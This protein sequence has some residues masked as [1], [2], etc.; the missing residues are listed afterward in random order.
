MDYF[1]PEGSRNTPGNFMLQKVLIPKARRVHQKEERKCHHNITTVPQCPP[2][3]EINT[4]TRAMRTSQHPNLVGENYS[5]LIDKR[6]YD[7]S[8]DSYGAFTCLT[9]IRL[10]ADAAKPARQQFQNKQFHSFNFPLFL[11]DSEQRNDP[12]S[13][14]LAT[15]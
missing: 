7:A 4:H 14:K 3:Q 1:H 11:L 12:T 10:E 8:S 2:K 6:W 13:I 15:T 5:Q 9:F